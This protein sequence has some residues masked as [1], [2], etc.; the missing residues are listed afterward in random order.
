MAPVRRVSRYVAG[1]RW[2]LMGLALAVPGLRLTACLLICRLLAGASAPDPALDALSW[3]TTAYGVLALFVAQRLLIT[4]RSS[5]FAILLA[6]GFGILDPI[7]W[8]ALARIDTIS[9]L[10]AT[11]VVWALIAMPE[12]SRRTGL[13][14][15]RRLRSAT[16]RL[17]GH[18]HLRVRTHAGMI[19]AIA[20]STSLVAVAYGRPILD[21]VG[22]TLILAPVGAISWVVMLAG[23]RMVDAAA[24]VARAT[25]RIGAA[26]PALRE[27]SLVPA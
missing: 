10:R 2:Q 17:G 19:M 18:E 15:P 21:V 8:I 26:A 12:W 25:A 22:L 3:A 7:W 23:W 20:V 9:L 27:D 13:R 1:H 16:P 6:V 4:G 5:R 24:R 14:I 11:P